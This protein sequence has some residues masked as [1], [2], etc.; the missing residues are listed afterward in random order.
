[1]DHSI[2]TGVPSDLPYVKSLAAK[3][4]NQLGFLP[5][6]ALE[7]Y[8]NHK[9]VLLTTQNATTAGYILGRP[10]FRWQPLMAPITQAAVAMDAQRRRHGIAL[11]DAWA[12]RAR[13]AGKLAVQAICANDV[14]AMEFWP[15]AGFESVCE[16]SPRN[17]RGRQLTCWRRSLSDSRP[18]WF[19]QVP[20]VAG[21]RA[22][23]TEH[24]QLFL[25]SRDLQRA[26]F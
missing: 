8:L 15:A 1:M 6:C 16:L 7:E 23:R 9:W 26:A 14:E 24:A 17:A 22:K 21:S 13:A 19:F 3:F 4:S 10:R 11:V 2:L 25:F 18:D 12:N 20:P 5:Q